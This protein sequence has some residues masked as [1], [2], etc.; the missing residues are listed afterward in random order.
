MQNQ[1]RFF[2][3]L[4]FMFGILKVSATVKLPA[5]FTSNMVLQQQSQVPFWG[6]ASPNK[7][8]KITTS[9][10]NKTVETLVDAFGKWK[11]IVATP[12]YGG[13]FSIEISDGKKL[14]LENVMIGEVWVC[15]GQS[16]ME[17]ALAGWGKIN[18]YEQ[19]IEA[20]NYPTIRLLQ[21]TKNTSTKPLNNLN[22][23]MG[24][25][26]V[27]SPQTV[28]EFSAVAYFFG[29]NLV[30]NT[31]IPI[32]LINTSW[33]GTI[34]EAWTSASTLKT[35][36]DFAS[37]VSEMEKNNEKAIDLKL[38]YEQDLAV[39]QNLVLKADKGF[40]N[41]KAVWTDKNLNETDWKQM[42]IP[43]LWEDMDLNNFD[44]VVWLRK[45]IDIPTDWQHSK[46]TLSLDMIDDNDISYFNGI[47]IGRT[48]GWNLTR[49]YTIPGNLVAPGKAV[50]TVRVFDTSGGGGIYGNAAKLKLSLT[51]D[52][53]IPLAGNWQYKTGFNIREIP[54]AP[55]NWNDPN[56]PT[57]LY[58]AMIN[59]IVPFTIKGA[60][61]YQGESNADRAYQYREL[62]PLMIKD[63]RKK[64]NTNFPFYFVQL[65]NYTKTPEQPEESNWAELR[66]AQLQTLH[67]E[68]TGM[69]VTIDIGDEKDIHPKNKQEV[70]RR[71]AL[72]ARANTYGEK[73]AFSGPIYDSYT[74]EGNSIRIKFNHVDGGLKTPDS[75]VLKGFE[76]A[77]LDHKFR[78]ADARIVGNEVIVSSKDVENP[79]AVRYAW[80]ANPECNLYNEANLPA[81]PFR[82]D[83]WPGITIG[84]K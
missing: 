50:I 36:P 42:E 84:R 30:E 24:G 31:K 54:S 33:G 23:A 48:E 72:I 52:K 22:V 60:I 76:I 1:T 16:N 6:E 81:S 14:T 15:S 4:L 68:N 67:L 82:T 18:N 80:A 38:K 13:P 21:V 37:N 20:A 39:W 34:A 9:W 53:F 58:N 69:A 56:R 3:V 66:E 19:E 77:G 57:V 27:C 41:D 5:I 28:A 40:Q 35:M 64:W 7:K 78:W 62:F 70:G 75:E 43:C 65:A 59:P 25:W 51:D 44:G 45:T 83:D 47:E 11:A 49:N 8:L 55:R 17:M 74:I 73:I 29:K 32:G 12:V 2:W 61:W 10:N 71:L 26:A 46:L 63:W 79:I